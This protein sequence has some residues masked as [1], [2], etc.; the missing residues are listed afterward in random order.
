MVTGRINSCVS[1]K[2]NKP[3]RR[4]DV[5]ECHYHGARSQKARF[6]IPLLSSLLGGSWKLSPHA[7]HLLCSRTKELDLIKWF[8]REDS[9]FPPVSVEM[10]CDLNVHFAFH[11]IFLTEGRSPGLTSSQIGFHTVEMHTRMCAD[12]YLLRTLFCRLSTL[13]LIFPF[14]TCLLHYL[15]L[16]LPRS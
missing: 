13:L 2:K 16:H 15:H 5:T 1:S 7:S 6:L 8:Q 14:F 4:V 9:S 10:D 3:P 11:V 12:V